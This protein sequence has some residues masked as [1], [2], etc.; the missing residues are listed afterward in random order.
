MRRDSSSLPIDDREEMK[1][2]ILEGFQ[3]N[4]EDLPSKDQKLTFKVLEEALQRKLNIDEL[5]IDILKTL[6]LYDDKKGYNLAAQLVADE[7]SFRMIDMVKFGNTINEF[8]ERILIENASILTAYSKAIEVYKRYF[9]YERIEGIVRKKI[10]IIPEDAFREAIVNALAHRDWSISAAIKVEIY[11]QYIE[12]SSPGGLPRGLSEEEYI[13]GQFSIL[14][15]EKIGSLFN[16]LGLIE[17]F[18]T[19]IKRIRHLY[20]GKARKPIFRV[21]PNTITVRLPVLIDEIQGLS[22]NAS[23]V[24]KAISNKQEL[25]RLE[26]EKITGFDKSKSLRALEQLMEENLV[27]KVGQGRGTKYIKV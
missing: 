10:E 1:K 23:V 7:N 18:G 20:E 5:S 13:N 25:S 17:R 6:G 2:L 11:D 16:R 19:G 22:E 15:N 3:Q 9:Q 4:Y 27:K 21:Y 24:L 8:R 12:I 26:I 14:R